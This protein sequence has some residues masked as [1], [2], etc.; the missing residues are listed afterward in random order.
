M[1]P[2]GWQVRREVVKVWGEMQGG[3]VERI[4]MGEKG[5]EVVGMERVMTC[6]FF[7]YA[8]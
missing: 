6:L 3:L 1:E 7:V 5:L 2:G 4:K 8:F